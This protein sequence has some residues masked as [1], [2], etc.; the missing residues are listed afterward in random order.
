MIQ[1][2]IEL[3]EGYSDI[4]EL[5]ELARSNKHR[6]AHLLLL[7]T[8]IDGQRKGSFVVVLSPASEGKFQPLYI[9]REGIAL[10]ESSKRIE[11]F[12][13]LAASLEKKVISIDVRSSKSFA[14]TDLYYQYLIGILRMNRYILPMQ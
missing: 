12:Q 14:E 8:T 13:E 1:R 4:Y 2:F 5:F 11:L 10:T 6:L 3:G 7:E 9:S